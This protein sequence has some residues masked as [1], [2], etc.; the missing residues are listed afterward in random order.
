MLDRPSARALGV[1]AL[2]VTALGCHEDSCLRGACTVPC[3]DLRFTCAAQPLYV[4]RVADAPAAYRLELGQGGDDDTLISNGI[5]TAVISALDAPNDLAPTGGTIVDFGAA[6]GVDDITIIYQLAGILPEDAFAYRTLTITERAD[7]VAVT[8]RG[9]LDGRPDVDVVTHYELRGCDQGLRVRS[10]LFNGSGD[11][12]AFLI[13]DTSHWG[14]RRVVPFVP[15]R[16]QGYAQPELDLLELTALWKPHDHLAAATPDPASPGYA[17]IACDRD[18]LHGVNDLEISALGT[19]ITFMEPGDTVKLE[20]YLIASGQGQGPAP[21]ID[22]ALAARAQLFA[23]R[24]ASVQG[25]IVAGGGPFGGDVRRAS[26][27]VR[28]GGIPVS[29][30]VP[31]ADGTFHAD[32]RADGPLSVEVWS[33]GRPVL[34]ASAGATGELGDLEV[35]VPATVQLAV[36]RDGEPGWALVAFHPADEATRDRV[37]GT[38]HGRLTPCAPWLGPPNGAS[39]ACNQVLVGPTGVELEV[40]AGRYEVF[41]SAGPEHTL[42]KVDL[43]LDPGEHEAVTLGLTSLDVAPAGWLSADLHVHGRASFDSG[44]PDEDRVRS[45]AA[46]GVAVIAAT[47]HDVIGDYTDVVDALGLGDRIAVMGGLEATQLIPW[48]DVPGEDVPRVIGHFNFWPLARVP[49]APRAGAPWDERIE[50][51]VLFDRMEALVGPH[52]V[53]MLNHPWDEPLFG[54]DLGYLRAVKF[55]PRRAIDDPATNNAV[56]LERPGGRHRNI[57]WG[58]IEIL[59][60]ADQVE[61]QKARVVWHALLAQGLIKPGAGNSDSHGMIDAQLGWAR[62]WVDAG[63]TVASFDPDRFNTAVREGRM[64]AGNGIVI[65]VEVGPAAGPRRGLGLA[66]Y[67]AT[68]GDVLAITVKAPPWVPV[69]EVRIVTSRGTRVIAAGPALAHPS[70]PFGT[71]GVVRYQA[72]LALHDLVTRDDF[73]IVEAGLPYPDAADLDDD[74]V[75]D[76]TDNNGDGVIDDRD[77]E[78]DEDAGPF[79]VPP[80]P[81]DPTDP[82]YW[83][84]RVVPGAWPMAFTNPLIIDLDGSGWLPPGLP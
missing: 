60:G 61:L 9:T 57:D 54:R 70:D 44:F 59:N 15:A 26:V 14:K 36:G 55:D 49:S 43:D 20:R 82:R 21:A 34:E 22:Q 5:V 53:M 46:A 74:G 4:G 12:Q 6:G 8:V 83:V 52:G 62:N 81:R 80:D 63:T 11:V 31:A 10:E 41:A 64:V 77:I 72:T 47:D 29:A 39:P 58:L 45:F 17:S 42:A 73:L 38:F 84:T 50:P 48:L 75:P 56:L 76:T 7:A 71:A 67:A 35:G 78:P 37:T 16:D 51:G 25:R 27:I 32:V 68:F 30:V 2:T 28:A 65:T 79:A 33:F 23:T 13:A 19:P 1:L 69:E 24:I 3:A 66:P 18:A 40:P